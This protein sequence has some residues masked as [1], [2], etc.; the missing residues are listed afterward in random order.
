MAKVIRKVLR[1]PI[2]TVDLPLRMFVR[3][4]RLQG[5]SAF[6]L[7]NL[8]YYI[9]DHRQGAFEFGAPN[10]VVEAVTGQPA[11]DFETTVRRY[12]AMPF[13]RRTFAN[14]LRAL[15]QF[16]LVPLTPGYN[17]QQFER[18]ALYPVQSNPQFV[19]GSDRWRAE[20]VV[21]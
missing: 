9:E 18:Q 6:E 2:L 20:H 11:E 10:S 4:A 5:V 15:T 14:R 12:L 7:S 16:S 19:M 1:S 8:R 17:F 13:A 21:L 3:A